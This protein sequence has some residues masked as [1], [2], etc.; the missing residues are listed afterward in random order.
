LDEGSF[1][2]S[3]WPGTNDDDWDQHVA[4]TRRLI[5]HDLDVSNVCRTVL[6]GVA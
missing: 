5:D 4:D 6:E 3:D 1:D 2:R